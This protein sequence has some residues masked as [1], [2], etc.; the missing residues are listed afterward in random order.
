MINAKV[1]EMN[2]FENHVLIAIEPMLNTGER[3]EFFNDSRCLF[4]ECGLTTLNLVTNTLS[5]IMDG[6]FKVNPSG[7]GFTIEFTR[8]GVTQSI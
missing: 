4:L 1:T 7:F 2:F 5:R 3:V 8:C 6:G